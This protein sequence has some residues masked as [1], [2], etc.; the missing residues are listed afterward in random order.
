VSDQSGKNIDSAALKSPI[1][2]ICLMNSCALGGFLMGVHYKNVMDHFKRCP[3]VVCF[4]NTNCGKTL[5]I[6]KSAE[7]FATNASKILENKSVTTSA[8]RQNYTKQ[9][10]PTLL[11]DPASVEVVKGAIEETY[12]Q[13]AIE[14]AKERMLPH[15]SVIVSCNKDFF[16]QMRNMD[17]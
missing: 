17:Q 12:E 8:A 16:I 13:K 7:L 9:T 5:A 11:H 4:G 2:L 14:T 6:S 15:G 1:L 10:F 3:T